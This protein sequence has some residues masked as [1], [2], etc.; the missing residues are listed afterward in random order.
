MEYPVDLHIHS[1]YSD[2]VDSLE[3]ILAYKPLRSLT[4]MSFAR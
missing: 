3:T 2:G 4:T 1:Y